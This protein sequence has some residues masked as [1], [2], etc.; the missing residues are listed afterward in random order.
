MSARTFW[1]SAVDNFE[2]LL[3]K[4]VKAPD[5]SP[6]KEFS[7][8]QREYIRD[9]GK[10]QEPIGFIGSYGGGKSFSL[11]CKALV[12]VAIP[13]NHIVIYRKY[14]KDLLS[15]TFENT[16]K[17]LVEAIGWT[18]GKKTLLDRRGDARTLLNNG[19]IVYWRGLFSTQTKSLEPSR[20]GSTEFGAILIDEAQEMEDHNPFLALMGRLRWPAGR[21][22]YH[23][24][25]SMNPPEG[26]AWINEW[27]QTKKMTIYQ[28]PIEENKRN[29]PPGYIER[30]EKNYP[31]SWKK[32]FLKGEIG[33]IPKGKSAY[34][35]NKEHFRK[36]EY[37]PDLSLIRGWDFGTNYGVCVIGQF[38]S[39][40]RVCVLDMI[41]VR[42]SWTRPLAQIVNQHCITK[43]PWS[44][45][46]P[47][48][49]FTDGNDSGKTSRSDLSNEDILIEEGFNPIKITI[50]HSTR[51]KRINDAIERYVDGIPFIVL[52]E[53]VPELCLALSE[54]YCVDARGKIVKDMYYEHIGDA[55]TFMCMGLLGTLTTPD[56]LK[57]NYKNFQEDLDYFTTRSAIKDVW[58]RDEGRQ[59]STGVTNA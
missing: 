14:Q 10:N 30:M 18:K 12:S 53:E 54:G 46:K 43:Y 5:G 42:D 29:L 15:T 16:F 26:I 44:I 17:P 9:L 47:N 32:K 2:R 55:F 20:L 33:S 21:G 45:T 35:F 31:E 4:R 51:M 11:C 38:D 22:F 52:N 56:V 6:F 50:R 58:E 41:I 13:G 40:P 7:V 39:S 27:I 37:C 59:L 1:N 49:D 19:S 24:S 25:V 48:L 34:K 8:S 36:F 28:A 3:Q 57:V 23:L